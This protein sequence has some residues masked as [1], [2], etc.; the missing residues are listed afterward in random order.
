MTSYP[1]LQLY[2][3]GQWRSSKETVPVLNPADET[4]IGALPVASR[5]DL[6]DA[7]EAAAKGFRIWSRT[8]PAKR[9][10]VIL[11]AVALIKERSEEIARSITM[12]HGK[13]IAQA[14]LEV[15]RGCEF[16]EWDAGEAV[17][18]YGRVI[19]SEPDIR[20]IVIRQPVVQWPPS[21]RGISR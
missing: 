5:A 15:Q 12:E 3:A 16:F 7:L 10:E 21:H 17:R 8:A 19:P 1:K 20:Y 13:P 14:R 11:R 6:D 2:I 4:V 9:A 18:S